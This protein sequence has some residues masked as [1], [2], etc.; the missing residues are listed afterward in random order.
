VSNHRYG[1]RR[2]LRLTATYRGHP[3]YTNRYMLRRRDDIRHRLPHVQDRLPT[4][5]SGHRQLLHRPTG[6]CSTPSA[7]A[8]RSAFSSARRPSRARSDPTT[9]ASLR[10]INGRSAGHLGS[11][12]RFD[13]GQTA[14]C[15]TGTPGTTGSEVLR[16]LPGSPLSNPWVGE[17]KLTAVIGFHRGR[18][19]IRGLAWPWDIFATGDR[20]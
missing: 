12:L 8:C 14:M 10:R 18:I 5:A 7:T 13:Y 4:G 11:G 16:A 15:P 6:T 17:R 2:Q 3:D 9:S 19:E 1:T 20:V